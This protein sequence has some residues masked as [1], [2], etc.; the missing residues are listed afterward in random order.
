M[1]PAVT[2]G[3]SPKTDSSL[4]IESYGGWCKS[5]DSNAKAVNS[6]FRSAIQAWATAD[7]RTSARWLTRINVPVATI[8]VALISKSR[9][10]FRT[11]WLKNALTSFAL[12]PGGW[13]AYLTGLKSWAYLWNWLSSTKKSRRFTFCSKMYLRFRQNKKSTGHS[14]KLIIKSNLKVKLARMGNLL[15]MGFLYVI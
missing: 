12:Q 5:L 14:S 15:E 6:S 3:L 2:A 4:W 1:K 11:T 10:C 9:R 13:C 8:F 7:T